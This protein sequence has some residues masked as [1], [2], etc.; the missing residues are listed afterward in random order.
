MYVSILYLIIVCFAF[1][2][3]VKANKHK[4]EWLLLLIILSYVKTCITYL[5]NASTIFTL[6]TIGN[7][8]VHLDDIVLIVALLYC[9]TKI[10]HPFHVGQDFY[11]TLLLLIPIVISLLR[12]LI[13]SSIDSEMFLADTRKY[14]LFLIVFY[15]VYFCVSTPATLARIWKFENYIDTLMNVV[16][17]YILIIW[18]LDL[19]L[20]IHSL[21]GQQGGTLSD[22]GSTFRIINPSQVLMIAF[23]TLYRAFR[24]LKEESKI[25][26]KTLLFAMVIMLLQWRTVVG[27]FAI[28]I[29]VLFI[30]SI[31]ENGLSRKLFLEIVVLAILVVV[32]STQGDRESGLLGMVTNLFESFSSIENNTGTFA[33]RTDAWTL[34][35][36][37]LQGANAIFG[38]PFGEGLNVAWTHSAH[39]GYVDY[40]SK[41]GYFGLVCLIS[42]I[43]YLL[44]QSIRNRDYMCIILL[45]TQAIYWIGYGFSLEQGAVLGFILAIQEAKRKPLLVGGTDEK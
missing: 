17:I 45:L 5:F 4:A 29:I 2:I 30:L 16:L 28:G 3:V 24:E 31:K 34:I 33:T 32:V 18:T 14:F 44:I 10:I 12:G 26:I 8:Q 22:G 38:M 15:A 25:S 19:V 36:S 20:G 35:L 41:M 40:I 11:S 23:Y 43:F 1:I 13:S 9:L 39:S 21:P 37:S 6:F 7:T 27:A 42:F